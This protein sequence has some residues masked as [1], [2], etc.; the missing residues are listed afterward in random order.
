MATTYTPNL[1]LP[2]H[3]ITDPFDITL[4]NEAMDKTDAAVAGKA[5]AGYGLGT[6]STELGASDDLDN[7]TNNGNYRWGSTPPANAPIMNNY[8]GSGYGYMRVNNSTASN[9]TQ[10]V[11]TCYSGMENCRQ[12]RAKIDGVWQP[13]EW[14]NPPMFLGVEHRTTERY[15]GAPVY[16]KLIDFG[17]MPAN[18]SGKW[19]EHGT[20]SQT[21]IRVCGRIPSYTL[22]LHTPSD[23]I[24]ISVTSD[25]VLV[26]APASN[27]TDWTGSTGQAQIWYTK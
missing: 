4:I 5:P 8:G 6:D 2:K 22:P 14:V 24:T 26:F 23:E 9:C 20:G 21:P 15:N 16:T 17:S 27:V 18:G 1:D 3:E 25:Y 11:Y 12:M 7:V 19:V 10:T 13:W